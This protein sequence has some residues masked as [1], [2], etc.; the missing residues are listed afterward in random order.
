MSRSVP[1]L[2]NFL[3]LLF[4]LGA[5][6]LAW[7]QAVIGTVTHLTGTLVVKQTDGS[8]KLLA[9]SSEVREGDVVNTQQGTYARI[10]FQDQGELVLRPNSQLVIT[11]YSYQEAAPAEDN[12]AVNLLKGGLRMV[13]GLVGKRNPNKVKV[14]TA[15]ATIGIRGT[16]FGL[17]ECQGDCGDIP[18]VT[19]QPP[20]D[21]L[22]ADVA[23]GVIS[24]T[25]D[26][27]EILIHAGE[28]GYA[29]SRKAPPRL[30]SAEEGFQ[31]TLPESV[32]LNSAGGRSVG[33]TRADC[34]CA[35]K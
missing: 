25:T 23:E 16:H 11:R 34:N 30:V 13:T 3:T 26:A 24:M 8:A 14:E 22:H 7:A 6:S 29:A 1:H 32:S 20:G 27:G 18:T 17:L 15:T 19:G 9:V 31:V 21:G 12:F 33:E 5:V 10:R 2:R 35:V 28:F 4:L